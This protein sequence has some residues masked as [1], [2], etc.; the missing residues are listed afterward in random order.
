MPCHGIYITKGGHRG[1]LLP[2]VAVQYGWDRETFLEHTCYKAGLSL[3]AWKD[4]DR[5]RIYKF[6]SQIFEEVE[7]GGEI[8]EL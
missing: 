3:D 4:L 2:Q 7:P 5:V 1:V 6:Q 8:V